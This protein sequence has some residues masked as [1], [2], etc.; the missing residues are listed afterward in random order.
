MSE[1]KVQVWLRRDQIECVITALR[2]VSARFDDHGAKTFQQPAVV[3][4][5]NLADSTVQQILK[6]FIEAGARNGG[7]R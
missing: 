6:V 2:Y 4:A 5:C 7:V 3:M 1:K